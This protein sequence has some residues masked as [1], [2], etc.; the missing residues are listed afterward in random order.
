MKIMYVNTCLTCCSSLEHSHVHMGV[1]VSIVCMPTLDTSMFALGRVEKHGDTLYYE[2]IAVVAVL[3]TELKYV[4][5]CI[6]LTLWF[7]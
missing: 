6:T 1:T 7:Y 2:G 3:H 5:A 4:Y